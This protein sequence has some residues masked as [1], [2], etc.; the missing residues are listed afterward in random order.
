[1][2]LGA[3]PP[4]F[5]RLSDSV[6]PWIQDEIV[7]FGNTVDTRSRVRE[8]EEKIAKMSAYIDFLEKELAKTA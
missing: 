3:L 4:T 5:V 1:M 7:W 8:L 6:E 2:V